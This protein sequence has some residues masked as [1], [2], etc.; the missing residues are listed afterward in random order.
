MI[1]V[2]DRGD[3]GPRALQA[4]TDNLVELANQQPELVPG[5]NTSVFRANVPQV[6]LDVDRT[7]LMLKGVKTPGRLPDAPGVPGLAVRQRLQPLRP[8]LAGHRAGRGQVP[9][10]EGRHPPAAGAQRQRDDGSDRGGGRRARDQRPAGPDPV[11]HVP[12]G[13]DQRQRPARDQLG[14]GDRS[15][16]G[17]G[18]GRAAQV[19]EL[20][21]DR[22]G[23]PGAPGRQHG[24]DR[25]RASRSSWSSW[26]WRRS[27][28]AGRCRWP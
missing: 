26:C 13:L 18:P 14:A 11:Q 6:F 8:H 17:A 28:R 3:L 23:L 5:G 22:A 19:D 21:V 2:E 4:Q 27:S 25:L 7:A 16:V 24:H 9:R 10:P 12:G 15:D 20:R 1:M